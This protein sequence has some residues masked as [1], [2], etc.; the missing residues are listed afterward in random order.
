MFGKKKKKSIEDQISDA[1]T[2]LTTYHAEGSRDPEKIADATY[3]I[4]KITVRDET[5]SALFEE[6]IG[7]E[8]PI[9][10]AVAHGEKQVNQLKDF[11]ER[12]SL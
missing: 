6:P 5:L 10:V 9:I 8:I 2:L 1:L 3:F 7:T 12:D 11:L 4:N